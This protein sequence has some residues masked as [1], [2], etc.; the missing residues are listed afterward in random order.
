MRAKITAGL[1]LFLFP[2]LVA[3]LLVLAI[4]TRL[5]EP[6]GPFFT[7]YSFAFLWGFYLLLLASGVIFYLM[8]R[9][10]QHRAAANPASASVSANEADRIAESQQE[11]RQL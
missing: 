5:P 10:A 7:D 9:A 4:L 6:L 11:Q 2:A 1:I 8:Q 3:P